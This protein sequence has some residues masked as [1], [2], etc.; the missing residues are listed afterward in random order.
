MLSVDKV[1]RMSA[2]SFGSYLKPNAAGNATRVIVAKGGATC[3]NAATDKPASSS[4]KASIVTQ[5]GTSTQSKGQRLLNQKRERQHEL[6]PA[7]PVRTSAAA[8]Q[9][10][11]IGQSLTHNASQQKLGKSTLVKSESVVVAQRAQAPYGNVGKSKTPPSV[12]APS[13]ISTTQ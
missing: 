1:P 7:T 3:K 8:V 5:A 2:T 11:L 6:D 4:M 12:M 9:L 10:Q 13:S